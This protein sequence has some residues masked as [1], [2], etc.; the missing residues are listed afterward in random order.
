MLILGIVSGCGGGTD[1]GASG[2][3]L[4]NNYAT[5][6]NDHRRS[7]GCPQLNWEKRLAFVAQA[8]SDDMFERRYVSHVSPDGLDTL[9]RLAAAGYSSGGE[10]IAAGYGSAK[11]VLAAWLSSP[12][13]RSNIENCAWTLH[14]VGLNSAGQ[15]WTHLFAR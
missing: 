9:D 5:M 15:V 1:S 11:L 3:S 6:V 2:G 13:H 12:S 10:N 8:H 4:I 14:G 7:I